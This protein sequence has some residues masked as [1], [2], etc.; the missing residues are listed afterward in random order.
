MISP[1]RAAASIGLFL[2]GSTPTLAK[3]G[4]NISLNSYFKESSWRLLWAIS[5]KNQ[6]VSGSI[7]LSD[8]PIP[9]D[10]IQD[11]TVLISGVKAF[12]VGAK[13]QP[14]T[15]RKFC[16]TTDGSYVAPTVQGST[17][18]DGRRAFRRPGGRQAADPC[19]CIVGGVLAGVI[20]AGLVIVYR[21]KKRNR[22]SSSNTDIPP[23][24]A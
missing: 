15:L 6:D 4:E 24:R 13:N 11:G 17:L 19:A 12:S 20:A 9:A 10:C 22:A 14:I 18:R 23:G 7:L 5:R 3:E 1:P 2:N 16:V 8:L 21:R